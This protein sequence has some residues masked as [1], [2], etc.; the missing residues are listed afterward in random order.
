MIQKSAY[1]KK[2]GTNQGVSFGFL[3]LRDTQLKCQLSNAWKQLFNIFGPFFQLFMAWKQ[4]RHQLVRSGVYHTIFTYFC[5]IEI[6]V[7]AQ[8][9]IRAEFQNVSCISLFYCYCNKITRDGRLETT[10]I[11]SVRILEVRSMKWLLQG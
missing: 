11:Y 10:E 4:V 2:T 1:K 8:A 6:S 5:V 3:Y 7:W 9:T